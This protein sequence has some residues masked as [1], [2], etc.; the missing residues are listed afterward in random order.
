MEEDPL[1]AAIVY[2]CR[3]DE[4]EE[5]E[6]EACGL[7]DLPKPYLTDR[8]VR[9]SCFRRYLRVLQLVKLRMMAVLYRCSRRNGVSESIRL[10]SLLP[11]TEH[12]DAEIRVF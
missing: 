6:A 2:R 9:S 7:W 4:E 10:P 12:S 3:V 11:V 1:S 8:E 5:A